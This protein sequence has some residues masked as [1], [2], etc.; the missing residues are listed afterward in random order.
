MSKGMV[1]VMAAGT[2]FSAYGAYQQGKAQKKMYEYNQAVQQGNADA[3]MEALAWKKHVHRQKLRKI[4]GTQRVLFTKAGVSLQFTPKDLDED[5]IILAA[6][7]EAILEYNAKM[8]A[9][10]YKAEGEIS[11]LKGRIADLRGKYQAV[12]TLLGGG[13]DTYKY[14]QEVGVFS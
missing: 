9:R 14:G 10:G 3:E 1:A 13:A 5:T 2:L 7:D 4:Q 12:G 11:G 8:K 6:Q